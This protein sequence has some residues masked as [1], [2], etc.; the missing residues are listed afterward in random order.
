MCVAH[1]MTLAFTA[2]DS[3]ADPEFDFDDTVEMLRLDGWDG[4]TVTHPWKP[5]AADWAGDRM[6]S[7]T[8][9]LGAANTLTFSPIRGHNTDFTGFLAA[10]RAVMDRPPGSVAVA[11]AGGVARAVVPAL[12]ALGAGPVTIWDHN[13]AAASALAVLTGASAIP[14][15]AAADAVR[16]AEGLVNAT[17]LG[18]HGHPGTAIPAALFGRQ[19]WAFDAVY[20][21]TNTPFLTDARRAGLSVMTGFDLFRHMAMDS[22]TAY[23][24]HRPDPAPTLAALDAL[25]PD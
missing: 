4:V 12:I 22:F 24:G 13:A 19:A 3:D 11:G 2:I 15:A 16:A 18:M 10:W 9:T 8:E 1:G 5:H 6:V 17:P 20:T 23:T 25:R 14:A 7:G 21:P